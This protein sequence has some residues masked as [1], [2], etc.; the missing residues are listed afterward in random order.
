MKVYFH[1]FLTMV[2][3]GGK[4][5]ASYPDSFA[6]HW[7]RGLMGT[8]AGVGILEKTWISCSCQHSRI[9]DHPAHSIVTI[10]TTSQQLWKWWPLRRTHIT[11]IFL[12]YAKGMFVTLKTGIQSRIGTKGHSNTTF[13]LACFSWLQHF[14]IHHILQTAGTATCWL[15]R[16]LLL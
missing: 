1:L 16:F 12:Y 2:L 7:T 4:W 14:T 11:A 13:Q 8:T 6:T 15:Q 10:M 9:P 3:D 5:S